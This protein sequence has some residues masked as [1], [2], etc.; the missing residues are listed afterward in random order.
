MAD[1]K[2]VTARERAHHVLA[3][4]GFEAG[5]HSYLWDA[6]TA[7]LIAHADAARVERWQT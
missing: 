1:S 3:A 5:H 7:A 2:G 4:R 6:I